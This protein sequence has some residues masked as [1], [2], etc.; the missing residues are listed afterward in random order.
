MNVRE[1]AATAAGNQ[2]LFASALR[3]FEHGDS[4]P[5]LAGLRRAEEASST[6]SENYGVKSS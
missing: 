2:N 5:A 1:V 4:P 3:P 6:A